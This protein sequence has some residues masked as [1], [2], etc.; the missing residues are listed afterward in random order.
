[1]FTSLTCAKCGEVFPA[2]EIPMTCPKCGSNSFASDE[3]KSG[4][5]LR[6][7]APHSYSLSHIQYAALLARYSDSI[8]SNYVEEF[9]Y[10]F[11]LDNQAFVVASIFSSVAFLECTMNE[12][13]AGIADKSNKEFLQIY[14]D[15][16]AEQ[17]NQFMKILTTRKSSFPIQKKYQIALIF[18]KKE[19]LDE[20]ALP[21]Q[22]VKLLI[23]LRNHLIHA[24]PDNTTLFTVGEIEPIDEEQGLIARLKGG[25]FLNNRLLKNNSN[26][27]F[28]DKCL[29]HGCADWG[30]KSSLAYTDKFFDK[31][32]LTPPYE[33]LRDELKTTWSDD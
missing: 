17:I 5:A 4:L 2:N 16:V 24:H 20:G 1:M 26:A 15:D 3:S 30:V 14:G 23:D 18:C 11:Y 29:G 9:K 28:P 19:Q 8:E 25:K 32:G 12:F 27:F 21:A 33:R 10:K 6:V 13:F 31:I 7:S 22:S